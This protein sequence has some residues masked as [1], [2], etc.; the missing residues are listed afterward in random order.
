MPFPAHIWP[1]MTMRGRNPLHIQRG[2]FRAPSTSP[3]LNPF[4]KFMLLLPSVPMI[5]SQKAKKQVPGAL[6]ELTPWPM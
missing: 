2:F 5:D 4:L 3:L 6:K 1:A